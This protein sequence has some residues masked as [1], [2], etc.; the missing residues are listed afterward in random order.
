[1]AN[2]Q[3]SFNNVWIEYQASITSIGSS[4]ASSS[5]TPSAVSSSF[6]LVLSPPPQPIPLRRA[7][8]QALLLVSKVLEY[9]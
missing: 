2:A 3:A 8:G 4:S 5:R 7:Q 1:M 6:V 9:A